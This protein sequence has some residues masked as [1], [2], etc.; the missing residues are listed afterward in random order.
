MEKVGQ[1][2]GKPQKGKSQI[3]RRVG[4]SEITNAEDDGRNG[5]GC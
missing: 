5:S 3:G 2:Y 4:G 1:E